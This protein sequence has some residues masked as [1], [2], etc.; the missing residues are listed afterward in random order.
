M[1]RP[2][3]IAE[4]F[5]FIVRFTKAPEEAR[6]PLGISLNDRQKQAL[7]Y[8]RE[9]GSIS[10]A[11]YREVTGVRKRQAVNDLNELVAAGMVARVGSGPQTRYVLASEP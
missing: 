4:G 5:T 9:H 6:I 11:V 7:E 1:P 8:V 2:E 3:F 10:T